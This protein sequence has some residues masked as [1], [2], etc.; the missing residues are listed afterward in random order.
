MTLRDIAFWVRSARTDADLE[1]L[2]AGSTRQQAFDQLYA[3]QGDPYAAAT[4][5]YRYQHRKYRGLLSM[6]PARRYGDV[7]DI[8][9][10]LGVF[11]RSL[12]P[13]ADRVVGID[14]SGEAVSRARALSG[15]LDNVRYE[16][17]DIE[18]FDS[19]ARF[20]LIVLAD[21]VYYL[22]PP[23]ENAARSIATRLSSLLE[24]G[25]LLLLVNHYF[26]AIDP[27]SRATRRIHDAVAAEPA[28]R[29]I[30]E[31][32]RAFWLATLF[33]RR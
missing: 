12:A 16:Q 10:G 17:A 31:R 13:Y 33:E 4:T 27:P 29:Q 25:G 9:C 23:L 21:V 15:G 14:V 32:R 8:G 24:A 11:T 3:T 5:K 20:S 6:L 22:E 19:D 28:L 2:V 26:F 1:R 30:D 18:T 7:L